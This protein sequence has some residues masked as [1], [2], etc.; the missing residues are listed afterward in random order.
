M[1]LCNYIVNGKVFY[2]GEYD[3]ALAYSKEIGCEIK[4]R[5]FSL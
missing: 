1:R 5:W 4:V 2:A 3:K